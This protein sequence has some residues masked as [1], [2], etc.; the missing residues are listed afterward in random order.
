MPIERAKVGKTAKFLESTVGHR[1]LSLMWR[2]IVEMRGR[3]IDQLEKCH[4]IS[5]RPNG[6]P[7]REEHHGS[8]RLYSRTDLE[9]SLVVLV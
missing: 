1:P 4:A 5:S 7:G 6:V 2:A 3:D 9:L 8:N